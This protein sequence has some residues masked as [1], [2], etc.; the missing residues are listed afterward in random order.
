MCDKT[1]YAIAR[2]TSASVNAFQ[3]GFLRFT[4]MR[5]AT[6]GVRTCHFAVEPV[7]SHIS[8]QDS[9]KRAF[10]LVITAFDVLGAAQEPLHSSTVRAVASIDARAPVDARF[11]ALD[12]WAQREHVGLA[13]PP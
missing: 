4:Q 7:L 10:V 8:P 12:A 13:Q 5:G 6:L 11:V 9:G 2:C 3:T 1:H